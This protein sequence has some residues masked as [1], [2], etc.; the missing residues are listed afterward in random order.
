MTTGET[1]SDEHVALACLRYNTSMHISINM[2]PF[3]AMFGIVAFEAWSEVDLELADEEPEDPAKRLST[4]HKQLHRKAKKYRSH[5]KA[6][7]DK[8][9]RETQYEI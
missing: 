6:Q 3:K 5:G 4:L 8:Q 7:Y 1:D 9:V 2:K